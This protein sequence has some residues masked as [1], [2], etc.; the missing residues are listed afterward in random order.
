MPT[1]SSSSSSSSAGNLSESAERKVERLGL[2]FKR[3]VRVL[4]EKSSCLDLVFL[5]DESS[6]VGANNFLSELHFVRK[7]LSDFPVAPEDTRVALVTFSSKTHVVTRVDHI[8]APK[9][10]QHKCSLLNQE[11]PAINYRGGGT[12]TKGAFQ[13]A[14]RSGRRA[15][16]ASPFRP[17][18]S[19]G[20][21]GFGSPSSVKF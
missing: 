6:S 2:A 20:P 1:L 16:A 14:A 15:V 4:R 3:N 9:S 8:S 13:R 18:V 11:I 5:V 19:S 7:M 21:Q 10:H 12:Y 17:L